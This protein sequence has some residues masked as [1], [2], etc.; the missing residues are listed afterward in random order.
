MYYSWDS[1]FRLCFEG[2]VELVLFTIDNKCNI[3]SRKINNKYRSRMLQ[4]FSQ[5]FQE[6]EVEHVVSPYMT[7]PLYLTDQHGVDLR[8]FCEEEDIFENG[9][10]KIYNVVSLLF[11][12][13]NTILKILFSL[14]FTM[15][16]CDFPIVR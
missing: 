6:D 8:I 5:F 12:P 9:L 2:V 11:N 4:G 10:L 16:V 7:V 15:R 1:C 13:P 3:V 14:N